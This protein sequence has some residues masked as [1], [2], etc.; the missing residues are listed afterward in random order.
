[1]VTQSQEVITGWTD[2]EAQ[3]LGLVLSGRPVQQS[4]TNGAVTPLLL[5][6]LSQGLEERQHT[7]GALFIFLLQE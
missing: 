1:M 7:V 4:L 2:S 3:P 6:D 5:T